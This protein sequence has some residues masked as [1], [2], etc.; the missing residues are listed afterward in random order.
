ML[1]NYIKT[2]LRNILRNK[3]FS[4]INIFG[5]AIGVALFTLI[6]LFVQHEYSYDQFHDKKDRIY[7]LESGEWGMLGPAYGTDIRLNFPEVENVV[8]I[9]A[10]FHN[11]VVKIDDN[12][13]HLDHLILADPSLFDVFT[14]PLIHGDPETALN[15]PFSI[16]LTESTAKRFFDTANPVGKTLHLFNQWDM[17]VTAIMKDVAHSHL[18][19]DAVVPFELLIRMTGNP[20]FMESRGNWNFQTFVLTQPGADI[21]AL[22]SKINKFYKESFASFNQVPE[23]HLRPLTGIYFADDAVYTSGSL[24]GNKNLVHLFIAIAVFIL[25]IAGIN[26][27]NLTTAKGTVRAKEIGI[28]KT[29]GGHRRQLITQFLSESVLISFFAL[30][31]AIAIIELILPRFNYLL[32][33]NI[34]VNYFQD[35]V[36]LLGLLTGI[37]LVGILAGLYPAFYLTSYDPASVIKGEVTKG[38]N[39]ARLRKALIVFQFSISIILIAG[40]I[41]IYTQLEYM[42]TM[43]MGFNRERIVHMRLNSDIQRQ[44]DA[45]E[46]ELL[47]HPG[48]LDA[49]RGNAIPGYL[50]WQESWMI[51][52]ELKQFTFLPVDPD[53][54][55]IL[56]L[57]LIQGRN[58][59]WDRESDRQD[60]YI[61]NETAV[62]YFGFDDPVG[63]ELY[64]EPYGTI[65]IIGIMRDFHF[66]SLHSP[67]G[68]LVLTWRENT[69]SRALIHVSDRDLGETL[70][71]MHDTWNR[72]SPE[73]PF[74]YHFLDASIER[75]YQSEERFGNLFLSFAVLALFIACL[76]LFGLASYMTQ[77]K[78]KEIGVRK[79]LGSSVSQIVLLLTKEFTRWVIIANIIAWPVAYFGMSRWLESFAY[80][81]DL[82]LWVFV[83]SAVIAFIIAVLTVG[84][85][86]VKAA[87]ANPVESLRYE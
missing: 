67:I 9:D 39:A 22:E 70:V 71:F 84:Y 21:V 12:R 45:F 78:T 59:S 8:R 54:M 76:G 64:I 44:W 18:R 62:S 33:T 34:D 42:K 35:P 28:R 3:G 17:T 55:E 79:V 23:F 85:Q 47:S 32:A 25:I 51:D 31:V 86:T 65:R 24:R 46:Q 53:Y 66:Q 36:L 1:A 37:F 75:L 77:Q 83:T 20:D 14:Y 80:R 30:I 27:I 49:S 19:I 81:I 73:Y 43:D 56:G 11:P 26:F 60:T 5:L 69:L 61:L 16:V 72:F 29:I 68:P 82:Q 2:A 50:G 48:V 87:L 57:E 58:F 63:R 40:T 15:D 38:K 13:F 52:E 7:R 41:V 6:M 4:F 10:R 74:E